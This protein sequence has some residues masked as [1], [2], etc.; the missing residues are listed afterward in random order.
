MAADLEAADVLL[1]GVPGVRALLDAPTWSPASTPPPTGSGPRSAGSRPS[2]TPAPSARAAALEATNAALLR[3]KDAAWAIQRDR[4]RNA[5]LVGELAG[6]GGTGNDAAVAACTSIQ[7]ALSALD[8]LEVRGRDS[9]GLHLLVRGHGLD[10]DDAGVR[11]CS[12]PGSTTRC[13]AAAPPAP[14]T[15]TSA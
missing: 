4:L 8:R 12:T 7:V 11:A 5:R 3:I 1:R 15:A 9:A 10:L 2:S 13:S 14:P 6:P